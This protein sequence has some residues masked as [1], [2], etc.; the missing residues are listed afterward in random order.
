MGFTLYNLFKACLL[1][2]N[3]LAILHPQRFLRK[4]EDLVTQRVVS[5]PDPVTDAAA[6]Q[7]RADKL[8]RIEE[9]TGIKH[10]IA[11]LL[12]ACRFMRGPFQSVSYRVYGYQ[13]TTLCSQ[14]R[15]LA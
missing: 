11:G 8:D 14:F 5:G 1:M 10:Q 4:C 13:N 3:A 12:H 6:T 9:G 7:P 2:I 15:S